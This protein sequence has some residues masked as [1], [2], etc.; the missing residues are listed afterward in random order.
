[1]STDRRSISFEGASDDEGEAE[2]EPQPVIEDFDNFSDEDV[3]D[4][5]SRKDRRLQ[6]ALMRNADKRSPRD[7]AVILDALNSMRDEFIC[8]LDESIKQALCSR[9]SLEEFDEGERIFEYGETG[10]KLY[11]I[12]SGRVSI[13]IP[14]NHETAGKQQ[15]APEHVE[16]IPLTRLDPG[17]SFGELALISE[18]KTRSARVT[19]V[20]RTLLMVLTEEDYRWGVGTSQGSFVK[21]RVHFLRSVDRAVLEDVSEVDMRAMAGHLRL[22]SH[23]GDHTILTQGD[24]VDRVIFVKSG[25]CKVIR[26]LHPRFKKTFDDY[27]ERG[28][29]PPNPFADDTEELSTTVLPKCGNMD[30]PE[31]V[32]EAL[33]LDLGLGSR[34]ALRKLMSKYNELDDAGI[35]RTKLQGASPGS[36]SSR[37]PA[38]SRNMAASSNCGAL[39]SE[40]LLAG[41]I[42]GGGSSTDNMVMLDILRAGTSFGVMEMMEGLA[43][44][45]SVVAN[46]WA[47]VYVMTK[48]DLIRNTSKTILHKLFC[49]YK[50]HLPDDRLVHRLKQKRRWND[51]KRDLFDQIR[52]RKSTAQM[53]YSI[54]RRTVSRRIGAGDLSIEDCERVGAGEI[55]WDKRAQTPPKPT[56]NHKHAK[57]YIF[58]VHCYRNAGK[59]TPEVVVEHD[60]RDASLAALE[61]KI[62]MTIA[63]ARFRDQLRRDGPEASA[64]QAIHIEETACED[65]LQ[66]P[67]DGTTGG[68]HESLPALGQTSNSGAKQVRLPSM[69]RKGMQPIG[70]KQNTVQV[71]QELEERA[72]YAAAEYLKN[73]VAHIKNLRKVGK[74]RA[75]E[76]AIISRSL[77]LARRSKIGSSATL[78]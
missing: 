52:E 33:A 48:Y 28:L 8:E 43:Y 73:Q 71:A 11:L 38:H 45:S 64:S 36:C 62:L 55:L 7:L 35:R 60:A 39:S 65:E 56:Y 20:K 26:Q 18:N 78:S 54:D 2:Q 5:D 19:A 58:H 13:D 51:Y 31:G 69:E 21:E 16:L 3:P 76:S 1:M 57:E 49:D 25:F 46:P 42:V 75:G 30:S 22:E 12:W 14:R 17:R 59:K 37:S 50:E 24:E 47:Q 66:A 4:E 40:N 29:P 23:I 10:D 41:A 6:R 9:F 15:H 77:R 53:Q 61:E 74:A 44:Q 67:E 63:T 72:Q 27:A 70:Q 34:Q 68:S 32:D